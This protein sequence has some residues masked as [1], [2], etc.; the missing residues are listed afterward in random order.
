MV[1]VFSVQR[2]V[3]VSFVNQDQDGSTVKHHS[4]IPEITRKTT[5]SRGNARIELTLRGRERKN[6]RDRRWSYKRRTLRTGGTKRW[7]FG[8]E[9]LDRIRG[10]ESP[11]GGTVRVRLREQKVRDSKK[12]VET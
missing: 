5:Y 12:E 6:L 4:R 1:H 7:G 3:F 8:E 9:V 11:S 10:T 2:K